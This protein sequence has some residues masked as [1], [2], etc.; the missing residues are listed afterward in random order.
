V[1]NLLRRVLRP[2][3]TLPSRA[4]YA[5]WAAHYPPTAHNALMKLEQAAMLDLLPDPPGKTVLDLACGSGRY[6]LILRGRGA[7]TVIGLDNSPDMLHHAAVNCALAEMD[8]IPLASGSVDL[9][10]CGLAVGHLPTER[11]QRTFAE[12]ARILRPDGILL[13]SDFHPFAY[14]S[15][16]R[17]I[18][19]DTQGKQ[20]AVEHHPHLIS[21]YF[22]AMSTVGLHV[23]AIREIMGENMRIPGVLVMR[24]IKQG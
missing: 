5:L 18:F 2:V 16:G 17:R 1:K 12:C 15:G 9:I 23:D 8:T 11:M 3:R 13:F 7:K 21:E 19:T 14:L 22:S 20:Y 4:A 10:V 6:A 24:G